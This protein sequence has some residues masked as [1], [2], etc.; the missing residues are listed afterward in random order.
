MNAR[1]IVLAADPAREAARYTATLESIGYD[2]SRFGEL[3]DD[4]A[5]FCVNFLHDKL[6]WLTRTMAQRGEPSD[7]EAAIAYA[8]ACGSETLDRQVS[9]ATRRMER[10]LPH[11]LRDLGALWVSQCAIKKQI[12]VA[13]ERKTA[14]MN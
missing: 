9:L 2:P 11:T 5:E 14:P 3:D 12:E 7:C 6:I 10:G 13:R 4:D 1:V 8:L